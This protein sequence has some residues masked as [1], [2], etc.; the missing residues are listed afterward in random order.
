M[1]STRSRWDIQ[2]CLTRGR[3][4]SIAPGVS[5]GKS[6]GAS[7][8]DSQSRSARRSGS[9][10][11]LSLKRAR[12]RDAPSRGAA[13]LPRGE[14]RADSGRGANADRGGRVSRRA[15][16]AVGVPDPPPVEAGARRLA[17]DR[18]ARNA[19]RRARAGWTHRERRKRRGAADERRGERSRHAPPRH[20]AIA[21][22]NSPAGVRP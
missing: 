16:A 11:I 17:C 21:G 8:P 5:P 3:E 22:V 19:P 9:T 4:K 20:P 2:A 1:G 7:S 6:L 14:T 18:G 12:R 13:G 10:P 15:R